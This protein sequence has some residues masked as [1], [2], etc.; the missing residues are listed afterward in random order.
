MQENGNGRI[1]LVPDI[2]F[3]GNFRRSFNGVTKDL[4]VVGHVD[5]KTGEL[6]VREQPRGDASELTEALA[7][8]DRSP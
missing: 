2:F 6:V 4:I 5:H 8:I 7:M 3:E 1:K